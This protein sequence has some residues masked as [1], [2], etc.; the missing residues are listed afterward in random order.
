MNPGE[1]ADVLR[2]MGRFLDEQSAEGLLDVHISDLGTHLAVKW[3]TGGL[4]ETEAEYKELDLQDLREQAMQLRQGV[5][6]A[7]LRNPV[8]SRA[9]FLRTLGQTLEAGQIQFSTIAEL[10]DGYLVVGSQRGAYFREVFPF[11]RLHEESEG[12]RVARMGPVRPVVAPAAPRPLPRRRARRRLT[13]PQLLLVLIGAGLILVIVAV[14]L[15]MSR[16]SSS[17][18]NEA[19]TP[20]P[21]EES[22]EDEAMVDW[23]MRGFGLAGQSNQAAMPAGEPITG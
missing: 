3:R 1:Y 19:P 23:M 16:G 2:A 5:G 18:P 11:T 9:E 12:R 10:E 14:G 21:A 7:G 6:G 4:A 15:L 13:R 17:E 20:P 22:D 8:T